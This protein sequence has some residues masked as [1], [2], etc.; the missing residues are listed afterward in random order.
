MRNTAK[1]I[2]A[3][4]QRNNK[5]EAN[6]SA[7]C[8]GNWCLTIDPLS[9]FVIVPGN[10]LCIQKLCSHLFTKPLQLYTEIRIPATRS[11]LFHWST[12]VP[13]DGKKRSNKGTEEK[14]SMIVKAGK[15]KE[16]KIK[17]KSCGYPPPTPTSSVLPLLRPSE[18]LRPWSMGDTVQYAQ[19]FMKRL[20]LKAQAESEGVYVG[21]IKNL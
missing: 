11:M 4:K 12:A 2:K 3:R 14:C 8:R 15:V 21:S 18:F 16:K 9:H 7:L 13:W 19:C 5:A 10:V 6:F 17:K 20:S 1:S